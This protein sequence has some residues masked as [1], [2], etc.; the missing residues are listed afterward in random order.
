M[1]FKKLTNEEVVRLS[2]KELTDYKNSFRIF[3]KKVQ[4]K[5]WLLKSW[6]EK[7]KLIFNE[8]KFLIKKRGIECITLEEQIEF[9]LRNE[10]SEKSNYVTPMVNDYYFRLQNEKFTFFWGTNSPF[11]QSYKSIFKATTCLI[12]GISANEIKRMDLLMNRFPFDFQEYSSTG[13]FMMY[14]KAIIFLDFDNAKKIMS[15]NNVIAI[16]NL[17]RKIKNYNAEIW[18]YYRSRIL[19]EGNKAKFDQN[20]DLKVALIATKGTTL[21]EAAPNDKIWGIGL[22]EDNPK[23]RSRETWNG[24]NLLGEILTQI[25]VEISG[26]Y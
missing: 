9:A 25:R 13:Q 16:K 22:T 20:E 6:E 11:S 4:D 10:P 26:N 5:S 21:V 7:K 3:N 18:T 2:P 17:G 8:Y 24:K 23:S 19:Y 15:T 14:H 12:E 1:T